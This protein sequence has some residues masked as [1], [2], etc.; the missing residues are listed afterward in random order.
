MKPYFRIKETIKIGSI[1]DILDASKKIKD[2]S[3]SNEVLFRGQKK[4]VTE[5]PLIPKVFRDPFIESDEEV[6]LI[7]WKRRAVEYINPLPDDQWDLLCLAQHYGLP[8]RLLDWTKNPLV[9]L[10]FALD[11]YNKASDSPVIYLY[12]ITGY[13]LNDV[14]DGEVNNP[15]PFN[16]QTTTALNPYKIDQRIS[17]QSSVFTSHPNPNSDRY[18][19]EVL[20]ELE[21]NQN[22][23]EQL[24]M[25]LGIFQINKHQIFPSLENTTQE[26]IND[27]EL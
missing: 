22:T 1:Q 18:I 6:L 23:I 14:Y 12:P 20:F 24:K 9:A 7:N 16:H 3:G 15:N 17:K 19:S 21:I 2:K 26:F 5:W 11:K 25:D 4:D 27:L 8:T 10:Y 13:I